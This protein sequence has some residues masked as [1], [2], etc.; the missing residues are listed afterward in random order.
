[1]QLGIG[2]RICVVERA[3]PPATSRSTP[4]VAG[5]WRIWSNRLALF[6]RLLLVLLSLQRQSPAR[7]STS[8]PSYFRFCHLHDESSNSLSST[9]CSYKRNYSYDAN[10]SSSWLRL[11]GLRNMLHRNPAA[12]QPLDGWEWVDE[13]PCAAERATTAAVAVR[14]PVSAALTS[15]SLVWGGGTT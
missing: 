5:C 7:R 14:K 10:L 13:P 12:S 11:M 15:C 3:W 9:P 1:M 2:T 6:T 4:P 8:R